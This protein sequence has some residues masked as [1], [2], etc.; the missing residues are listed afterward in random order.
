MKKFLSI[1]LS[2]IL[3]VVSCFVVG[4][5]ALR[6]SY[7]ESTSQNGIPVQDGKQVI[8]NSYADNIN[9]SK[10]LY[11]VLAKIYVKSG[12]E[13]GPGYSFPVDAF[14]SLTTLDLTIGKGLLE[15]YPADNKIT[16]LVGLGQLSLNNLTTLKI[17]NHNITTIYADDLSAMSKLQTLYITN[18]NVEEISFPVTMNQLNYLDL[19]G[20]K[21][22]EINA[23]I[24]ANKGTDVNGRPYLNLS[25][26][27]F[28][29]PSNI[30]LPSTYP[31][32]ALD[33][34]FNN[35]VGATAND[36][37]ATNVSIL[38]QGYNPDTELA[39]GQKIYVRDGFIRH[40]S[41]GVVQNDEIANLN[42]KFF[43]NEESSFHTTMTSAIAET[44]DGY[45]TVPCG[46]LELRFYE[47][48][49]LITTI[50]VFKARKVNIA[51]PAPVVKGFV[52]NKELVNLDSSE[53][54]TL[55]A[56]L[57][58]SG[59]SIDEFI[60]TNSFVQMKVGK[61]GEY[62]T[63][64][65]MDFTQ[66]GRYSVTA[67]VSFDGL[68]SSSVIVSVQKNDF[69]T[70]TWALI[71]VVIAIVL[72]ASLIY[73]LRW[74]REGAVVAPLT[75]NET[76]RVYKKMGK[77]YYVSDHRDLLGEEN[78]KDSTPSENPSANN[79]DDDEV[80]GL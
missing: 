31:L 69:T 22:T 67:V 13:P 62:Q 10:S 55:K 44:V 79:N 35:M 14:N 63:L 65:S 23:K 19:S 73:L 34:S 49:Q 61:T 12:N 25:R 50:D 52:G 7:A 21:L 1:F 2:A 42:A 38:L 40:E 5:F 18:S 54:I 8:T 75:D 68:D 60:K 80:I 28:E 24:L 26:N 47:G 59:S 76:R 3:L 53:K 56:E 27:L 72:V 39:Y 20:N 17:D 57:V 9:F 74:V 64:N 36:F 51:P 71:I 16:S 6:P 78:G 48:Q 15:D 70:L 29:K 46:K 30:E 32:R 11:A 4:T 66:G 45:I 43:F 58:L 33:V 37:N 77:E 41:G